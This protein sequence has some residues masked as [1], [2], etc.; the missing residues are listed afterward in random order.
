MTIETANY[1]L[2]I[3][4]DPPTSS[5]STLH[6]EMINKIISVIEEVGPERKKLHKYITAGRDGKLKVWNAAT[7]EVTQ[8]IPVVNKAWVTSVCY[9]VRSGIIVAG[10]GDRTVTFYE[11]ATGQPVSKITL[12]DGMPLCMGYLYVANQGKEILAIGDNLGILHIFVMKGKWHMC[13][14]RTLTRNIL[15]CHSTELEAKRAKMMT[16]LDSQTGSKKKSS[17]STTTNATLTVQHIE[18]V[19]IKE[20]RVHEGWITRVLLVEDLDAI[21]TSSLDGFIHFHGVEDY[22]YKRTCKLHQ[23]GIN[24]MVWS[25]TSRFLAS[26]GEERQ[27]IIWNAFTM[28]AMAT[29]VGHAE[30]VQELAVNEEK[31]HLISLSADKAVELFGT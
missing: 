21:I 11:L 16:D 12:K 2:Q 14:L 8:T 4:P 5:T 25:R 31:Q 13:D 27:I 9:M 18:N 30:P 10:A 26:C 17:A 28:T 1:D 15:C 23:K 3:K 22:K 24:A 19:T 7:L 20:F 29:L 6:K